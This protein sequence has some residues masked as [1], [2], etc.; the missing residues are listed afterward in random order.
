PEPEGPG[1]R[2]KQ[3][4]QVQAFPLSEAQQQSWML[5]QM[6]SA[7]SETIALELRGELHIAAL[8]ES[9]Q[10]IVARHEALRTTIDAAG[11]QQYI[12]PESVVEL[13][14]IDCS[15]PDPSASALLVTR[16]LQEE[17]SRP[18]NLTD[19]PLMRCHLLRRSDQWHTLVI[20]VHHIV[21][22]GWS[23]G[24]IFQELGA[25]YSAACADAL[26][27][28]APPMQ[29]SAY[30]RQ[31]QQADEGDRMATLEA[32][33]LRKC[34]GPMP[35]LDLPGDHPRPP[36]RS[37]RGERQS[38][39]Y[40]ATLCRR[41]KALSRKQN[42]T[43]FMSLITGYLVLLHRLSEQRDLCIGFPTSGRSTADSERMIG[44]CSHLVPLRSQVPT[45]LT[46][47]QYLAYIRLALLEAYEHQDYPY[48]RLL[49]KLN[50]PRDPGRSP[51]V[52]ATF[53]MEPPIT[54][55]RLASLQVEFTMPP[56]THSEFD[57]HLNIAE[58]D[59]TLLATVDYN[60]DLFDTYTMQQFLQRYEVVLTALLDNP[61]QGLWAFDLL[62][63]EERQELAAWN[64]TK[65]AM[66]PDFFPTL[67]AKQAGRTPDAIALAV[68]DTY[69][70]YEELE[71]RANQLARYLSGL[72][73][74]ADNVIGLCLEHTLALVIGLLGVLKT[75]AAFVMLDPAYP[76]ERLAF[77]LADS[78]APVL[79]TQ[80]YLRKHLDSA[81]THIVCLDADWPR[82]A[83]QSVAA[84]SLS[85][86]AD[87]LA[88]VIYTSGSTGTPKGVMLTH[89]GLSNYLL[90]CQQAYPVED[91]W[92]ALVHSPISADLT[93]T[94][95]FLPLLCG[96]TVALVPE[97]V[98]TYEIETVLR[99][100]AGS[101]FFKVTP[102]HLTLFAQLLSE[103]KFAHVTR[104]L[105]VGGEQ[106]LGEQLAPWRASA[107]ETRLFNEYGPTETVVGCCVYEVPPGQQQSG[108]I[109][110]GQPIA[111]T[112]LYVLD[113]A[114]CQ[115]PVGA[116]G[117][118]YIGGAG[119]ARGYLNRPDLTAER[120]IPNPFVHDERLSQNGA[121][122]AQGGERL[123]RTGDLVR[124]VGAQ[125]ESSHAGVLTF[126][127]R[128][129]HQI[130]IRGFRVEPG[131]IEAVLCQHPQVQ[132]AVVLVPDKKP[133]EVR[134]I[135]YIIPVQPVPQLSELR[136]FLLQRLPEHMVP[137]NIVMLEAFPLT[138]SG[139]IDRHAL[140]ALDYSQSAIQPES[141]V[142][143]RTTIE[144]QLVAIWEQVLG[145]H[146][147]GIY[148]N[149]FQLGGN[150]LL[151]TQVITRLP[152]DLRV[153]APLRSMFV[154]PTVASFAEL[155][156]DRHTVPGQAS[157]NIIQ[158]AVRGNK[159]ASQ[160]LT[161]I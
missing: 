21:I 37:Y 55:P 153:E 52:S 149:F 50:L 47:E 136:S 32:Y 146:R 44:Y 141:Y 31:Q 56:V 99:E 8:Q 35:L 12:A 92:G 133:G 83:Q 116:V 140:A 57:V 38:K 132:E 63:L 113:R 134:L 9:L 59:G 152:D 62:T 96:E 84:L 111:N 67:F 117:E 154:A 95:L 161:A 129:D 64:H 24:V 78:Q 150:S 123:Y 155:V 156:M 114:F 102:A 137:T 82:I 158:R 103:E 160:L 71:R 68:H 130:K 126:L 107:P 86:R 119:L 3:E 142:A 25:L 10:E 121:G 41:L 128:A 145:M 27:Q 139:K 23:I 5:S 127:G 70:S 85:L 4:Q 131:E 122:P 43:L 22:D 94:S 90:W 20:A 75:G 112:Q 7:G 104:S 106:L 17:S 49:N 108:A 26:S 30:L 72:G 19:G 105:I 98:H 144:Q 16:W 76:R 80:E 97:H 39:V 120:F 40:D 33:W 93:I 6:G 29:F 65:V 48:A 74:G 125:R 109:P 46:L 69:L 18:F 81:T 60:L 54:V 138:A 124:Y 36:V 101:S 2:F 73:V 11:D 135:A 110:I 34:A 51:L 45:N 157:K 61:E 53:N 58:I 79:I 28:L 159:Q 14:L 13:P 89:G 77:M 91:G 1:G 88:Y 100:R 115:V 66:Q 118:L 151:A 42:C 147:I 15:H 87:Q 143:P 148:D